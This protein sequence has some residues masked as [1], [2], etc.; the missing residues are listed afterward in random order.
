[1]Q[2]SSRSGTDCRYF[3]APPFQN[4]STHLMSLASVDD[5]SLM[6][7]TSDFEIFIIS[8]I[9]AGIFPGRRTLSH[10]LR[11]NYSSSKKSHINAFYFFFTNFKSKKASACNKY[12]QWCQICFI[13]Y[14]LILLW[15]KP[16]YSINMLPSFYIYIF[17]N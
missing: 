17:V 5:P 3:L 6:L 8:Y 15:T 14:L 4:T 9:L 12:L 2:L 10:Q 16:F 13:I 1:M 7:K 11:M